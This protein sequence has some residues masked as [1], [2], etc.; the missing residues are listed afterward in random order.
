MID[1]VRGREWGRPIPNGEGDYGPFLEACAGGR[2]LI[3][4][5][6]Q[7][8]NRQ[9]YPRPICTSCGGTPDW[10]EASGLATLH[11]FTVVRQFRARPFGDELPYA[12]GV[13]DLDEGVRMLGNI[14]DVAVDDIHVGIRLVAYG[15][16]F[17]PGRAV[18]YWRPAG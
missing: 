4:E 3:Q 9:F 13:V 12:V 15:V 2:L 16:E 8:G 14:T 18:P 1:V 6:P 10:L 17:E 11:T 5:C 7:C